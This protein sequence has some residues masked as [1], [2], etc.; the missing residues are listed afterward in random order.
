MFDLSVPPLISM[1]TTFLSVKL[2]VDR[3]KIEGL[4]GAGER[5]PQVQLPKLLKLR[6]DVCLGFRGGQVDVHAV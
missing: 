1:A 4:D 5:L 6:R 3:P 2:L